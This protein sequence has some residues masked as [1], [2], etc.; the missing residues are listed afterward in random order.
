MVEM[1]DGIRLATDIYRPAA[2]GEP[3]P[4]PFP[5][6]FHRTAYDKLAVERR[7]EYSRWFAERGYI[8][9]MQDVRGAFAS[10]GK[11]VFIGS[12]AEDGHNTLK[13]IDEQ[14]WSSHKV[15]T[16]GT[17]YSSFTQLA[18]ATYGHPSLAAMVPHQSAVNSWR[19]S[20][21]QGGAF[22]LRWFGWAM[23]HAATNSRKD[24]REDTTILSALNQGAPLTRDWLTR[25][26]IR[27]GETQLALVPEYEDWVMSMITESD[28][29]DYWKE[30]GY[31]PELYFDSFPDA[32]IL[33]M[34]GWYDSY[35]RSVLEGFQGLLD[36][37][38]RAR[39]IVGPWVHGTEMPATQVS[40]N[41]DFGRDAAL[42]DVRELHL[43]I[44]DSALK[45][46]PPTTD[47]APV[48][49]FVMGGG[50]GSR[51]AV[52]RLLHGGTWRDEQ[53]WPLARTRFTPYYLNDT[54][55]LTTEAPAVAESST[56]YRFDP[57]RPVPTIGSSLS[58]LADITPL[59]SGVF[60]TDVAGGSV[61]YTDIVPSGGFNQVETAST[62]GA[63]PPYLPL[64]SRR[65][66]L[67]FR[68]PALEEDLEVTGPIDVT[69]YVASSAVDT[70]FTAKLIDEYPPSRWHPRGYALNLTDSIVRLRYRN[71]GEPEFVEPG[72]VVEVTITL[73]PTSNLFVAGHRIRVDV[74]SS[75]FPRFDA[76]PNT[77]DPAGTERTLIV[78]NNT[79]HHSSRYPSHITLPLIPASTSA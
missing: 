37:G 41:V 65:D 13:W 75:N 43:S 79:V 68:T 57:S 2:D 49:L 35:S 50:E 73:Y 51:T 48:R 58:S 53:E 3:L 27:R 47:H 21:R 34:S 26:P 62:F 40:G 36:N 22:E 11:M 52:G 44:F 77:G 66:V 67:V 20:V 7:W 33:L 25:W 60:D 74:S 23:W 76:N 28:Y 31:A 71:G 4:G 70:D 16:W 17:S 18:M 42:D 24:L 46:T 45:G 19:S 39:V 8:A 78:A 1:P 55:S 38:R 12:E 30:R 69:L 72:T 15:G 61:R 29:S 5:V 59:P 63:T 64:G 14:E 9:I 10:E 54:G 6:I 56:T 32:E